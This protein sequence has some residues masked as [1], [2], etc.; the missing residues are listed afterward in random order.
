[1]GN[2]IVDVIV[3]GAGPAGVSAAITLAKANK[4]VLLVDRSDSAG[5]K[6][7]FGGVIYAKQTA[8]IF[9]SFWEDAPIERAVNTQK[10][11]MLTDYNASIFEFDCSEKGSYKAFTV[12]RSKWDRWCVEQAVRQGAYYA[13]KTVVKSLLTEFGKVIGVETE[14]EK[15]YAEIVILAD[16]VNSLL[17]KQ[18]GLRKEIEDKDVTLAVKEVIKLPRE[19][20]NDRFGID[21]NGG[22]GCKVVGGPL[23][24][25]FAMGF[26]YTDK[27]AVSIGYGISLDDLKKKKITPYE[28]LDELKAHPTIA[29]LIKDGKTIEYSAHMIPEGGAIKLPKIY[30]DNVMIVGDAA[31]L[32]NNIHMEGT[33]LAMLSGKLAAETAIESLTRHDH[34]AEFLKNYYK[35]LKN[36]IVLKDL[37]THRNTV[38]FIKK[39]IKTLT[40]LYPELAQEFF[41]VLTE[42]DDVPKYKK[43]RRFA[44]KIIMSGAI[45]KSIPLGLFALEK[46]FK[47]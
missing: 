16:G 24:D 19:V 39:H 12:N 3:V 45:F 36:S 29:K 18:I 35:K 1:M 11:Y 9:P 27:D 15:Y 38:P 26:I 20:I 31:M 43:Y 40:N 44:R 34:S 10:I 7:M 6:N 25:V 28:L 4:K 2:D 46:C 32:V 17:A 21:D 47:K 23:K 13:P 41:K 42:A 5:D 30:D 37:Q 14:Q 22:C 33:N 8:E